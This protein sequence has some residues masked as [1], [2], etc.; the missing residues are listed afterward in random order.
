MS[1]STQSLYDIDTEYNYNSLR[2]FP[3]DSIIAISDTR[4]GIT[5]LFW[6]GNKKI[7]PST[8]LLPETKVRFLLP[9]DVEDLEYLKR[10]SGIAAKEDLWT[11]LENEYL[12]SI[13]RL[14]SHFFSSENSGS[15]VNL[16]GLLSALVRQVEG[17]YNYALWTALT[18]KISADRNKRL[19]EVFL[20]AR[21]ELENK[22]KKMREDERNA[23]F[24]FVRTQ[25]K[26]YASDDH[27]LF[28]EDMRGKLPGDTCLNHYLSIVY[29]NASWYRLFDRNFKKSIEF[30]KKGTAVAIT[31]KSR[32]DY[33]YVNLA[34]A[35]L[36]S[37][38][39]AEAR[40]Y[41]RKFA[42][43]KNFSEK[44]CAYAESTVYNRDVMISDLQTFAQKKMIPD[45]LKDDVA[46]IIQM[47]NAIELPASS[48]GS[49]NSLASALTDSSIMK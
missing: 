13:D 29:N 24:S 22:I 39:V 32:L 40:R 41:Y 16:R 31:P 21:V 17:Q 19:N 46:S 7:E 18:R 23:L 44:N 38:S 36:L 8:R 48:P 12:T 3:H 5:R 15:L 30:A 10:N 34:H 14:S 9:L 6:T 47:L 26:R 1:D 37:G 25:S 11:Y 45:T 33:I 43:S 35:H 49:Y 20:D 42:G 28:L 2:R 4:M 27:I